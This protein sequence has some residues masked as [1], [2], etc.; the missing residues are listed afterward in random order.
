MKRELK[1]IGDSAALRCLHEVES[2][3]REVEKA[4]P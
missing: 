2:I 3:N 4:E 1:Q